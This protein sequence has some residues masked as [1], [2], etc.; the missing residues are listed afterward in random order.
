MTNNLRYEKSKSDMI[1]KFCICKVVRQFDCP[2]VMASNNRFTFKTVSWKVLL[3]EQ[4]VKAMK[5]SLYNLQANGQAEG[6]VQTVKR[7]WSKMSKMVR[8][9]DWDW[10]LPVVESI[11]GIRKMANEFSPF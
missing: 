2:E 4:E 11:C 5:V 3:V 8:N 9:S 1:T 7:A 6:I 10:H